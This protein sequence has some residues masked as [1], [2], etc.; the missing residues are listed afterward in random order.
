M[1][2]DRYPYMID[3]HGNINNLFDPKCIK[4]VTQKKRDFEDTY[5]KDQNRVSDVSSKRLS[6]DF[7]AALIE[8]MQDM[9]HDGAQGVI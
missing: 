2:S 4:N 7:R 1:V 9:D 6:H 3:S 5:I 8:S